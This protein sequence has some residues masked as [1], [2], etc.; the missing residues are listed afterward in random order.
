[1]GKAA[2]PD[3]PL[4]NAEL[5]DQI[6][7]LA[8]ELNFRLANYLEAA[9]ESPDAIDEGYLLATKADRI[10]LGTYHAPYGADSLTRVRHNFY[11]RKYD[12]G[13]LVGQPIGE[14]AA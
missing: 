5:L 1:M 10:W 14:E 12:L 7:Q 8:D 9:T 3:R 4:T 2:N 6:R 13:K 11:W